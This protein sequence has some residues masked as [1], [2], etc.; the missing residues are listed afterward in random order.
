VVITGTSTG[1][2]RACARRLV[3]SKFRVFAGVRKQADADSITAE[4]SDLLSPVILDVTDENSIAAAAEIVEKSVGDIGLA[5]LVN[6][7][8]IAVSSPLEFVP[9]ELF[10]KQIEVNV[11]GA[12]AV[13]RAF[14]PLLRSGHGRIVNMG[15]ISGLHASPYLG[16]YCAS[17]FALE[18]ITDSL[19]QEL[20]P[21]G[22]HVSI[23]E[24]GIIDT[25]IWDKSHARGRKLAEQFSPDAHE[26]YNTSMERMAAM[27]R[28]LEKRASDP[29]EVACV[30]EQALTSSTPK[31]RYIVGANSRFSAFMSRW[32]PDRW[33][34]WLI[35][36]HLEKYD[37]HEKF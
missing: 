37:V 21:W 11:I 28:E 31:T 2:G 4:G 14:M 9:V 19:R 22:M 20:K 18:A 13:T 12:I 29:D 16:P 33:H 26:L 34:D 6:N 1:I 30:V 17:K 5:G 10:R 36:K 8:G 35:A 23:V 15:S 24:P 25:P 27:A 7:A 3:E 32:L